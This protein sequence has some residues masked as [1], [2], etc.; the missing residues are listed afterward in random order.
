M[1][2][3]IREAKEFDGDDIWTIFHEVVSKGDT[4]A[5][6]PET[7]RKD[8]LEIW[9]EKPAATYV[10]ELDGEVV[11]T[12]FIKP[13]QSGLGA[14]VCNCGYMVRG[15]ARGRGVATA[16]CQH[17][18]AEARRMG[19]MGM[20]FNF[21]VSTNV[22]AVRLWQK[23]GFNIVGTL[24]N[25]FNHKR[26]GHV[27]A[28]V[29]FKWFVPEHE[30]TEIIPGRRVASGEISGGTMT[31]RA[32]EEGVTIRF[33]LPSDHLK[34]ISVMPGWWDGRDLTSAMPR[35]FL[36]HFHDTSLVAEK[37]G[38]FIGFL[39]GFLSQS[40][41]DEGYIHFVGVHPKYRKKGLGAALYNRFFRICQEHNRSLVRSCT[42]PVNKGS[43]VFHRNM[44]FT[45]EPG[46][47]EMDGIP[48]TRDYNRPDDPKV[49]FTRYL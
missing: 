6:S 36:D 49:L 14:H 43:V 18:Q 20:Q 10:A 28:H 24:P 1:I 9:I 39:V 23:L 13:N 34:I 32:L 4:Y 16:M 44:G 15:S 3:T 42:S 12:Y 31:D 7:K 41:P 21:V 35:L 38:K 33:A 37:E 17:S 45:I 46:D 11:G 48:V 40:R 25:A 26:F 47:S 19:F 30:E 22:G 27:D 5:F 2:V 29:M 8:A